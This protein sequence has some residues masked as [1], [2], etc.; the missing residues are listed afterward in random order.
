MNLGKI[1]LHHE[2]YKMNIELICGKLSTADRH[3]MQE[4]GRGHNK[5]SEWLG[6]EIGGF[7]YI[8]WNFVIGT[9]W[10]VSFYFNLG[11]LDGRT[12]T[13]SAPIL[14]RRCLKMRSL[15]LQLTGCYIYGAY[16]NLVW[17]LCAHSRSTPLKLWDSLGNPSAHWRTV[18]NG[19]SSLFFNS[20]TLQVYNT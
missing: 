11:N 7:R 8:P 3:S 9:S 18:E 20:N 10:W 13:L 16:K 2:V 19:K 4:R 15:R 14:G 6:Q 17:N 5:Y 12:P 1:R